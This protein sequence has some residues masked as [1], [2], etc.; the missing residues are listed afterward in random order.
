MECGILHLIPCSLMSDALTAYQPTSYLVLPGPFHSSTTLGA[1]VQVR[2]D[3]NTKPKVKM[4]S[5]FRARTFTGKR[6]SNVSKLC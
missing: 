2:S 5:N 4:H 1:T 6:R 3:N